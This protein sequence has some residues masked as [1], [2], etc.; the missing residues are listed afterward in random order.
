MET[1]EKQ[2]NEKKEAVL[3]AAIE[4]F[5]Q[6]SY[7]EVKTDVIVKKCGISKGLLFHYYGSKKELYLQC[8]NRALQTLTK[9]M[10]PSQD[11]EPTQ[12]TE[13]SLENFYHILFMVMDQKIRLCMECGAETHFVN[14]AS[15]ETAAE[16]EEEK[17]RIIG[18]YMAQVYLESE[19]VMKKAVKALP[20]KKNK[21]D[22]KIAEG[23]SLYC[24][25]IINKYLIVYQNTPDD[26]FENIETVKAEI[27]E[28]ID[29]ML[30]GIL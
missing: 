21:D 16:V 12:N 2:V 5:S 15:R 4:E 6:K 14:M 3:R 8:L 30:Y 1:D 23:L 11:M 9:K 24:K 18:K 26:F 20:M 22:G 29:I 13:T 28:Y 27:K 25:T 10:Q 17:N 19:A 7:V